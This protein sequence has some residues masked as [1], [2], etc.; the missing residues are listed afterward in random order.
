MKKVNV[1]EAKTHLSRLLKE[2]EAGE[3][4][5]IARDSKPVARLVPARPVEAR[6]KRILGQMRGEFEVPDDFDEPDAEI[7]RM[8][9]GDE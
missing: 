2:V 4:I 7:E 3:E 1:H 6:R 5:L 8:F 9:Y